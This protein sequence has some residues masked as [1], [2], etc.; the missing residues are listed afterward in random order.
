METKQAEINI[1][2]CLIVKASDGCQTIIQLNELP[3]N[4]CWGQGEIYAEDIVSA[5]IMAGGCKH[6]NLPDSYRSGHKNIAHF[7]WEAIEKAEKWI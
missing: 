2:D 4:C 5:T 6:Y 3:A 1:G 7:T